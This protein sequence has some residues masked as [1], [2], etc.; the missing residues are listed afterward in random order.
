MPFL[1]E[2]QNQEPVEFSKADRLLAVLDV[3]KAVNSAELDFDQSLSLMVEKIASSLGYPLASIFL[4]DVTQERALLRAFTGE[5]ADQLKLIN[6]TIDLHNKSNYTACLQKSE[7]VTS[8]KV[9]RIHGDPRSVSLAR[10]HSSA[11]LPL[12]SSEGL[13][14]ILEIHSDSNAPFSADELDILKILAAQVSALLSTFSYVDPSSPQLVN[15]KKLYEIYDKIRKSTDLEEILHISVAE[16]CTALNIP[17]ATI[18][19][20]LA[21]VLF[22]EPPKSSST[23]DMES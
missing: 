1:N 14:G 7:T 17:K 4:P 20:N 9:I 10:M 6:F 18:R 15:Q 19:V 13:I 16:I 12:S 3:V 8:E 22:V 11:A 23:R 2:D 21:D 5:S